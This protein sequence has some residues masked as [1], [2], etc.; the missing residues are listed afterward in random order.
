MDDAK[1]LIDTVVTM[2]ASLAAGIGGLAAA[3]R[4][5]LLW[6]ELSAPRTRPPPLEG[7]D[8]AYWEDWRA[9]TRSA[10]GYL[11]VISI[12]LAGLFF[13]ALGWHGFVGLLQP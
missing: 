3:F 5:Q 2:V 8:A 7:E 4:A 6:D 10:H 11:Q 13:A 9:V 1:V 12:R